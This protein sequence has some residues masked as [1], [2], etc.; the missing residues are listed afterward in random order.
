MPLA[1]YVIA[2]GSNRRGRHGAPAREVTAAI[3]ALLRGSADQIEAFVT[4]P[5]A[6][7]LPLGRLPGDA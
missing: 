4:H 1:R 2:I 5:D 3:A 6:A 7:F